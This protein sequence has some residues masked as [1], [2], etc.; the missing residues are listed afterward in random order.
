MRWF[1]IRTIFL[2][3]ERTK[4]GLNVFE[5][6]VVVFS[7]ETTEKAF[8]KAEREAADYAATNRM[9]A[10]HGWQVAYHQNGDPLIDGYEVWSELYQSSEDLES[11]VKSRYE[12]Y[13]YHPDP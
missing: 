10:Q 13:E 4:D 9:K 1:G 5:E 8:A 12:K 7:A 3:G 6:R 11:F 2:W